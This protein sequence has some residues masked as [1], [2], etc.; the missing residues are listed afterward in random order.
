M[1]I[2]AGELD[3]K[4]IFQ[5]EIMICCPSENECAKIFNE[6]KGITLENFI[7][8]TKRVDEKNSYIGKYDN[9]NNIVIILNG[10]Y[11]INKTTPKKDENFL[12]L[13]LQLLINKIKMELI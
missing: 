12:I 11:I 8:L 3:G 9:T 7:A 10:K 4:K 13:L 1:H 5:S 2:Y 6:F